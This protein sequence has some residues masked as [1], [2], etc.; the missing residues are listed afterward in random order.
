MNGVALFAI[1]YDS[2][3]ILRDFA[4]THGITYHLLSDQGSHVGLP[5]HPKSE[6]LLGHSNA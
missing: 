4:A 3:E 5:L 2:V 6:P 1:S